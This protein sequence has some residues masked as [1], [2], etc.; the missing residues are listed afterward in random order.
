MLEIIPEK[1]IR[2]A[3]DFMSETDNAFVKL[4]EYGEE[5]RAANLTPIYIVDNVTADVYVTS[6]ERI[7]KSF[8]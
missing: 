1:R 7:Q 4:L 6:A 8:H 2:M 3:A 5:F